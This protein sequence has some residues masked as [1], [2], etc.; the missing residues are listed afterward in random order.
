MK[1]AVAPR[2]YFLFSSPQ[3][4]SLLIM[5]TSSAVASNHTFSR[6]LCGIPYHDRSGSST[7][8]LSLPPS[9]QGA[10]K[11]G[12]PALSAP[13]AAVQVA[14]PFP[15]LRR[16]W[17]ARSQAPDRGSLYVRG[18]THRRFPPVPCWRPLLPALRHGGIYSDDPT[19]C[20]RR[21]RSPLSCAYMRAVP[22]EL[23]AFLPRSPCPPMGQ[24]LSDGHCP[25][26]SVHRI[27][28]LST[29]L[30]LAA[31]RFYLHRRNLCCRNSPY[32]DRRVA[33][34]RYFGAAARKCGG[35][36]IL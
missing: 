12:L 18:Y 23:A 1:S 26:G 4:P 2:F 15:S 11:Y 27:L 30:P 5:T 35:A 14:P 24:H 6:L 29:F 17:I 19:L 21:R 33:F 3:A 31:F 9:I 25:C 22:R 28:C 7:S 10:P 34:S 32:A 8:V 13:Y 36:G 20:A 16:V